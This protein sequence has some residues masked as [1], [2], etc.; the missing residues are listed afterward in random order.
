MKR[1]IAAILAVLPLLSCAACGSQEGA[2]PNGEGGAGLFGMDTYL[3]LTAYGEDAEA[4]LEQAQNRVRELESLW[5]AT[6][7]H[8]EIYAA[9]HSGGAAVAVSGDTANLVRYALDMARRTD[10][11][12]EPTLY[13][14]LT[15]WGF[16]TDSFQIPE[17]EELDHLLEK[18]DYTRVSLQDATLTVPDGMQLDLGAVGKGY[19]ADEAAAVLRENG[20]TSALLDFGGN[21]LTVGTKPDGS[22][23]R[24]GV[25]DPDSE[26]NLGVLEIADQSVVVSGGYEKFFVGG[27]GERYWHI[28]D[29]ATGAPARSG[30]VQ[31]AVVSDESKRCDALSTA[32]FVM[33]LDKAVQYWREHRDFEMILLTEDRTIYV[34]EGLA[35]AFSPGAGREVQVVR[36]ET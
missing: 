7:E 3:N 11:S 24:V 35:D 28:L 23:W 10:G 8:S 2:A 22:F 16:T 17:R 29:P 34:T 15:A 27:D 25:R 12:L 9:N 4:A 21:I 13:P 36:Q 1:L 31:T 20:V 30:L 32:L 19:A 33:G 26:G 18:V 5:S 6:D 14:V